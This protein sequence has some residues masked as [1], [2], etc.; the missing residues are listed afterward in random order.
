MLLEESVRE[1]AHLVL[2]KPVSLDQIMQFA[3]R[4]LILH[5]AS[6]P[7]KPPE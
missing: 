1:M 7:S 2:Q 5:E 3:K 6:G 4:M